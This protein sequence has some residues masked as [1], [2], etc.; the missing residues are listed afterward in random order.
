MA[1]SMNTRLP[2]TD[3]TFTTVLHPNVPST[4]PQHPRQHRPRIGPVPHPLAGRAVSKEPLN[5]NYIFIWLRGVLRAP[6]LDG[7]GRGLRVSVDHTMSHTA[8]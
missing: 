8:V 2:S 3:A 7:L 5:S 4:R 1:I 6:M